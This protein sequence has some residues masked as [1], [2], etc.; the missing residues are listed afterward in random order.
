MP[1]TAVEF[2]PH[3][4]ELD[5]VAVEPLLADAALTPPFTPLMSQVDCAA[6]GVAIVIAAISVNAEPTNRVLMFIEADAGTRAAQLELLFIS[7]LRS[8]RR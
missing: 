8:C 6:A 1:F 3:A 7:S 5:P 2:F 4:N